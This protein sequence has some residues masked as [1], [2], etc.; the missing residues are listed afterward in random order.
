MKT[1][2][3][4]FSILSLFLLSCSSDNEVSPEP[5]KIPTTTLL[6]KV[7]FQGDDYDVSLDSEKR[8]KILNLA[9][10]SYEFFYENNLVSKVIRTSAGDSYTTTFTHDENGKIASFQNK[11]NSYDVSFHDDINL[12]SYSDSSL[13]HKYS[14]KI[15]NVGDLTEFKV[16]DLKY[17]KIE[18]WGYTFDETKKGSLWN[19]N[20]VSVYIY[21]IDN[22]SLD[23]MLPFSTY[24]VASAFNSFGNFN[25][26]N[27]YNEDGYITKSVTFGKEVTFHYVKK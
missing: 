4:L 9:D 18:S 27:Q 15:N 3:F 21:M 12:Y 6:D 2:F 17:L 22:N 20:A 8:V 10:R 25:S 14:L 1:I 16:A 23:T 24:P 19:S 7:T 11:N 26:T 5:T 13:S